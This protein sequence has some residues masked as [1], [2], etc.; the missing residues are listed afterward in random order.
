MKRGVLFSIISIF[1]VLLFMLTAEL[2]NEGRAQKSE[3]EVTRTRVRILNSIMQDM[4][5][6]YF[7][8]LLQ[9]TAKNALVGMSRYYFEAQRTSGEQLR[10]RVYRAMKNG[11]VKTPAETFIN[12]TKYS[13]CSGNSC[14][15]PGYTLDGLR[16]SIEEDFARVGIAVQEFSVELTDI[17]ETSDPWVLQIEADIEYHFTDV[18]KIATWEGTISKQTQIDIYG[19]YLKEQPGYVDYGYV[20]SD[21][22]EEVSF[23]SVNMPSAYQQLRYGISASDSSGNANAVCYQGCFP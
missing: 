22:S 4:Q 14:M 18:N 13:L 2:V 7:E 9:M 11:T 10:P 12:I 23:P 21:W 16:A 8:E 3:L 17:S 1:V 6:H 19:L 15:E 5:D 20:E